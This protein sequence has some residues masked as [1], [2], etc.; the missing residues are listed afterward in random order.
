M[1]RHIILIYV[2]GLVIN[3][4]MYFLIINVTF[5]AKEKKMITSMYLAKF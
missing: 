3:N 2:D 4:R 5:K 1:A